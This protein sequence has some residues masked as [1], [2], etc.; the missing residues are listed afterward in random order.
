MLLDESIHASRV[1]LENTARR[2]IDKPP[3]PLRR[4]PEAKSAKLL[5]N[6]DG[7]CPKNF[8]KLPPRHAS[9]QIH[10]PQPVLRH[11]V[12]LRLDHIFDGACANVRHAPVIAF[13]DHI[14]LQPWKIDVLPSSCGSGR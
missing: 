9:Q 2:R 4:A 1:R 11:D 5:I 7:R 12:T 13:D 3:V 10:L 14:F 6:I 8:R